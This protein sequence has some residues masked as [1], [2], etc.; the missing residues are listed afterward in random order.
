MA[1]TMLPTKSVSPRGGGEGYLESRD[2]LYVHGLHVVAHKAVQLLVHVIDDDGY[3][4]AHRRAHQLLQQWGW[5]SGGGGGKIL[6]FIANLV[7]NLEQPCWG[8]V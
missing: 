8:R 1:C 6:V 7:I 2:R 3:V 5:V 4:F